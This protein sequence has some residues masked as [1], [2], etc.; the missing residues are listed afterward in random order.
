MAFRAFFRPV[1]GV[2]TGEEPPKT[3]R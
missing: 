2:R 1:R 3:A